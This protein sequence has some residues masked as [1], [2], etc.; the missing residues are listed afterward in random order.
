SHVPGFYVDDHGKITF[1]G[2]PIQ[3]IMLDGDDLTAENYQLLS[4]NLRSLMIDSIQVL[5]QYNQNRLLKETGES[6]NMALNLILKP[7]FYGKPTVNLVAA[8]AFKRNGELQAELIRLRKKIKQL[9]VVNANNL[10]AYPLGDRPKDDI[11]NY[12]ATQLL[13]RSWPAVLTND[14][15]NTIPDRYVNL[16]QDWGIVFAN[17]MKINRYAQLRVS[18]NRIDQETEIEKGQSQLFSSQLLAPI[19]LYAGFTQHNRFK[20]TTGAL[21]WT[22]DRGKKSNISYQLQ[23]YDES[24]Q[25]TTEEARILKEQNQQSTAANLHSTGVNVSMI[26]TWKP[27][28]NQVWIIESG[29]DKSINKYSILVSEKTNRDSL[30]KTTYQDLIHFGFGFSAG[31]GYYFSFKKTN[32]K[33]WLR[34]SLAG[35][36]SKQ[37]VHMLNLY[38][39]KYYLSGQLKRTVTRKL[40]IELQSMVGR[41]NYT[42]NESSAAK[43]IYHVD[44]AFVW[45]KKA[46]QYVGLNIGVQRQAMDTRK[47]YAGTIYV[48]GT[49]LVK[50]PFTPAFPNSLYAQLNFSTIDL[51][52]GLTLA[53]QLLIKEVQGDYFM[54]TAVLP[55]YTLLTELSNGRQSTR[56]LNVQVEKIIHPLRLKYRIQ[57]TLLELNN[58]VQFNQQKFYGLNQIYRI[59]NF[60]ST[61]WKKGYNVQF[62]LHHISSSFNAV[63]VKD[64]SWVF[65]REY[66]LNLQLYLSKQLNATLGMHRYAGREIKVLDLFD[67]SLNG[68]FK[69]KY[70]YYL[71]G[72]NLL[73]RS[74]F[75]Q[76]N[77]YMNSVSTT[78]QRLIGR[79]IIVGFD[80]PL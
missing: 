51:Y 56:S 37:D 4:R 31:L 76:Q 2:K 7:T 32:L 22:A 46:T 52:R 72:S 19:F 28:V 1:N 17:T 73:N 62:E 30:N 8:Y 50:S 77:V 14:I 49:T 10:G 53:G 9:M 24:K 58:L 26:R 59:G 47:F 64:K 54:S 61:N 40:T 68:M 42:M 78:T 48:N 35:V 45:R 29:A 3:K 44:N 33:F 43:L 23:F 11:S 5:E 38:L 18:L 36:D 39:I 65:S 79:R 74:V 34:S 12:S 75:T 13:F 57:T 41:V 55:E 69:T 63:A 6:K 25:T 70:R 71:R 60:L 21:E 67:C 15:S 20:G 80:I 27:R 66:K 16:N